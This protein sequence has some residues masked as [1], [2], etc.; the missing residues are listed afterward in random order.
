MFLLAMKKQDYMRL[1]FIK[2]KLI[3]YIVEVHYI[4]TLLQLRL[5]LALGDLLFVY[6]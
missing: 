5:R 6:R 1:L 3:F 4:S 2:P